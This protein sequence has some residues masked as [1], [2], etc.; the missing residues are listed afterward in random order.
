MRKQNAFSTNI[1]WGG[2]SRKSFQRKHSEKCQSY[3]KFKFLRE[4]ETITLLTIQT[5]A[6][7]SDIFLFILCLLIVGALVF[8]L[9]YFIITLS[10]LE[11]DYLNAQECCAKLNFVSSKIL[12][13]NYFFLLLK[14]NICFFYFSGIFQSYG[15]N[16][17]LY[18]YY[19]LVGT[20]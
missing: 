4:T 20:G 14:K 19:W 15:V 1:I 6:V 11:C 10:D 9:I 17:S 12:I 3:A 2:A 5:M 8:V 16:C 7:C 18:L 13:M